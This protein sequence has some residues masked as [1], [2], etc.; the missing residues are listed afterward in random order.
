MMDE[1][2]PK[3]LKIW[4]VVSRIP[5]GFVSTYG[6]VASFAGY[7]TGA[8]V[9]GAALR[10]APLS[11]NLPWYRVIN[12]RGKISFPAG[13]DKSLKQKECLE[14]E[15]VVFV[16]G[17]VNLKHYAWTGHLDSELWQM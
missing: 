13:G 3:H 16:S 8:R 15:G 9:V 6:D 7:P 12:A 11:L 10:T 14:A 2:N 17:I 4:S 1:V 5:K